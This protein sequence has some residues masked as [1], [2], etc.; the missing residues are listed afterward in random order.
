MLDSRR[1][2][3]LLF[4]TYLLRSIQAKVFGAYYADPALVKQPEVFVLVPHDGKTPAMGTDKGFKL[5]SA[6]GAKNRLSVV[7]GWSFNTASR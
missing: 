4:R 5:I 6:W 7:V 1:F 2:I 3:V